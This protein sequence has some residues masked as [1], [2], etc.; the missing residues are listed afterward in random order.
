MAIFSGSRYD[1]ALL[2]EIVMPGGEKRPY[3]Y[4]RLRT[5][6]GVG[7]RSSSEIFGR[8]DM[9]DAFAY[10]YLG[11]EDLWW[12]LADVNDIMFPELD[13]SLHSGA[14]ELFVGRRMVIPPSRES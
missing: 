5:F 11:N 6:G 1:G 2:A 3:V 14:N 4:D 10:Q 13:E 7:S 9:L 12:V 8:G